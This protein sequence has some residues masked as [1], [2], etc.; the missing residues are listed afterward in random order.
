MLDV[1]GKKL[2]EGLDTEEPSRIRMLATWQSAGGLSFVSVCHHRAAQCFRYHGNSEHG[3]TTV[4]L[5]EF[6]EAIKERHRQG[7]RGMEAESS[8]QADFK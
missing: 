6:Q 2:F 8:T 5:E 3:G 4:S 7:S 1:H